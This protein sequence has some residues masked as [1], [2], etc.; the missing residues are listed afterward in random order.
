M[1][2]NKTE[3]RPQTCKF[4]QFHQNTEEQKQKDQAS[5]CLRTLTEKCDSQLHEKESFQMFEENKQFK[6]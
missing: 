6:K 5:T 4:G 1:L 2:R 3:G